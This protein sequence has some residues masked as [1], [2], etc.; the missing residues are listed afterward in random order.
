MDAVG[1]EAAKKNQKQ[2]TKPQNYKLEVSHFWVRSNRPVDF[3]NAPV[4][5]GKAW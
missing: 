2:Q 5:L 3:G 4:A 1:G